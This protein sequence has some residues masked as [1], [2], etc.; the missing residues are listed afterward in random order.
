MI[1]LKK[2]VDTLFERARP[3]APPEPGEPHPIEASIAA[4]SREPSAVAENDDEHDLAFSSF[5]YAN[6]EPEYH[7]YIENCILD[8]N[9]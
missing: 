4:F 8:R 5:L 7:E 9:M 6:L 2:R 1:N 3:R